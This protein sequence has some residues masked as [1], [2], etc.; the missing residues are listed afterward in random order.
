MEGIKNSKDLSSYVTAFLSALETLGYFE[1]LGSDTS[2]N[3]SGIAGKISRQFSE[4]NHFASANE[5]LDN[6]AHP[7]RMNLKFLIGQLNVQ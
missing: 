1:A 5:L 2:D 7:G 6:K 4:L 3:T